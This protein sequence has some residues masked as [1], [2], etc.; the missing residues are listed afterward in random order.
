ASHGEAFYTPGPVPLG[1]LPSR[2]DSALSPGML[3]PY[4]MY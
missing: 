3:P 4:S 1:E 2:G